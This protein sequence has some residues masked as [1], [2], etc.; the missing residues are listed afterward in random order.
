VNLVWREQDSPIAPA[1][2][3]PMVQSRIYHLA[4][5][6]FNGSY[7]AEHGVGPHNQA[8]FDAFTGPV[9]KAAGAALKAT[10]DPEGMLGT[11]RLW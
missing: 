6:D 7:S 1:E 11:V 8:F 3:V 5:R 2:L 9:R 10:L 4:V